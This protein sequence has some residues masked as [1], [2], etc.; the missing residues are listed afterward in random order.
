MKTFWIIA[1]VLHLSEDKRLDSKYDTNQF[2]IQT[3]TRI[4]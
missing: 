3:D 2:W 1:L 4:I